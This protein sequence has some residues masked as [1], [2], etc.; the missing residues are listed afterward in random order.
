M[1][2][3]IELRLHEKVVGRMVGAIGTRR[4]VAVEVEHIQQR[5]NARNTVVVERVS[6]RIY[7]FSAKALLS[8]CVRH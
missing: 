2:E 7:G 3:S 8:Q 6:G 5:E 1:I 4:H